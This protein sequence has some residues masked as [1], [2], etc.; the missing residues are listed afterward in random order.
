MRSDSDCQ[1]RMSRAGGEL[2]AH[3]PKETIETLAVITGGSRG[4][5]SFL[6]ILTVRVLLR[7]RGRSCVSSRPMRRL[8]AAYDVSEPPLS[9]AAVK[10]SINPL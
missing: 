6:L 7:R 1:W 10:L 2:W 9:G 8:Q 4:W 5:R 3:E